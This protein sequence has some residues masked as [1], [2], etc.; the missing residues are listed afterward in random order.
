MDGKFDP[1]VLLHGSVG[2]RGIEVDLFC[3]SYEDWRACELGLCMFG[4]PVEPRWENL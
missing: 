2:G 4:W 3:C 1:P